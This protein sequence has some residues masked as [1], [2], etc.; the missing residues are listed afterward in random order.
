LTTAPSLLLSLRNAY[1]TL[2]IAAPT[3]VDSVRGKL[4]R[5]VCDARL[6]HWAS[7][8]VGNTGM[9]VTVSGREHVDPSLTYL[10]M[11]NHQSH[12]DVA[13]I[14]YVLGST[15][16]MVAKRELFSIP[17]F[18]RAIEVAGFISVDRGNT[19]SAIASLEG[20]RASLSRGVPIWIAPEGTR[21]VTGQLLPFKNGGFV[22]AIETGAPILPVSIQ[23]TRNALRAKELRSRRDVD[24]RVTIHP[25]IDPKETQKGAP[26]PRAARDALSERV[27]AAIASGL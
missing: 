21:S 23:G 18:G 22:L 11:S 12:Y 19:R 13:V 16:R 5:D 20:A 1:E 17:V 3:V 25:A 15:I 10:I 9:R 8:V 14:Y 2:A 6:A 4:S 27:R 24:V 7:Q 26:N